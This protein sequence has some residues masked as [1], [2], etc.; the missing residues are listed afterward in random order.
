MKKSFIFGLIA[1]ALGFTAC[2]SVDDIILTEKTENTEKTQK[3]M[4][5]NATVEQPAGTRATINDAD[6][7]AWKFD[8]AEKD[9][10]EVT[11]SAI[12][13][14]YYTFTKGS[15]NFA[16]EDAEATETATKWYAYFPSKAIWLIGQTGKLTGDE[17]SVANLYALAGATD[18]D[19]TGKGKDSL[20]IKMNPKVA[21]IKINNYKGDIKIRVKYNDKFVTGL[22]AKKNEAG[23]LVLTCPTAFNFLRTSTTGTHYIVVPASVPL[24]ILNGSA[25]LTS[26]EGLT[27]GKYY[28]LNIA[29]D[30][31]D[32][33]TDPEDPQPGTDPEDSQ[34]G[35]DPENP[36]PGTDPENPQPDTDPTPYDDP[37]LLSGLFSVSASKKVQ[38]TKGNLYWDGSFKIEA[39]QTAY[40]KSW[41][42]NHIG[43]FFWTK[44]QAAAYADSYSDGTNAATDVPF[45]AQSKGGLTIQSAD[46]QHTTS[47]VYALTKGEWDYLIFRRPNAAAL[48]KAEV[49]V[50]GTTCFVIAPDNF[51]VSNWKG[52]NEYYTLEEANNQSL[53]CL[54]AAGRFDETKSTKHTYLVNYGY[55]WAATPNSNDYY[56]DYAYALTLVPTLTTTTLPTAANFVINY[57]NRGY[58]RYCLRLVK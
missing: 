47:G 27:A 25:V 39:T 20:T 54:P 36:Q 56:I 55:Y 50:G 11:N 8:F 19:V 3:G 32:P 26:T 21:I 1:A 16:S 33:G 7:D 6:A 30:A 58:D 45:F 48:R 42:T 5:L 38:F 44:D 51:D 37:N 29:A 17:R 24:T 12:T 2:S 46:G 31:P 40:P 23:F 41:D 49:K 4:V 18:S 13:N 34:P 22:I 57:W 35:T 14:T 10:L 53:L 9:T 28:V 15:T 43:H 52:E